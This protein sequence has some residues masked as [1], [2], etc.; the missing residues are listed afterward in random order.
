[1]AI[2]SVEQEYKSIE[3]RHNYKTNTEITYGE[4]G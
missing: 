1:M 4:Q 2:T 3:G